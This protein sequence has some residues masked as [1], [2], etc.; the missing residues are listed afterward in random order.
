MVA[1]YGKVEENRSGGGLQLIQPQFEIIG[2]GSAGDSAEDSS[3]AA[4]QKPSIRSKLDASCPFTN[5]PDKAA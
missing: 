2:D 3:D 5:P 4:E 1:L